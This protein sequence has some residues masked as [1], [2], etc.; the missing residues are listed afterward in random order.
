MTATGK[1]RRQFGPNQLR[2]H[3]SLAQWQF[4]RARELDLIPPGDLGSA[5]SAALVETITDRLP[6]IM[7]AVGSVPD[8]GAVRAAEYLSEKLN[9]E[10]TADGVHE[11]AEMGK[12]AVVGDYKGRP[13]YSGKALETFSDLD[14]IYEA[15]QQGHL[16]T[17]DEVAGRMLIR[18]VDF[19]HAVR[20]G[21]IRE[22]TRV[23]GQ[24]HT[25]VALFRSRDVNALAASDA[26]DWA[27]VRATPK[28]RP[29]LL[30]SLPDA[31][32]ERR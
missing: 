29:S 26:V 9:V 21:L 3:L 2:D 27:A 1:P 31:T 5:W 6:Y 25:E 11:L 14:A 4:D 19:D 24:W 20:A 30:A 32:K 16:S 17:A 23:P 18:R 10:V 22:W 28:G 8:V 15:E 12:L 7:A 13:L